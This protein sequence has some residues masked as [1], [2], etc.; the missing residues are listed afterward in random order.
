MRIEET[1]GLVAERPLG[2]PAARARRAGG[3]RGV[4]A[5]GLASHLV[6][7]AWGLLVAL[8]LAWMVMT[9]FK[10]DAEIFFSPWQLPGAWRW[11]NFARAW[12]E[13]QIGRYALN[14]LIVVAGSVSLTLLCA[15]MAAY[16][17]ARYEF[18]LNRPIYYAFLVGLAFPGFLALVPVFFVVRDLGLLGTYRGLILVYSAGSLPFAV[19]FLTGFF[20]SLPTELAEAAILDGASHHRVFFQIMLP[21]ARPGLAAAGIFLFL[22]HW[23]QF[24][25]PFVLNPDPDRYLLAQGLAALAVQRGYESDWSALFAGLTLTMLPTLLFYLLFQRRV[26]QGLTAGALKG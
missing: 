16:A 24:I 12:N 8:P 21:M 5:G 17:L 23:N 15:S 10:S 11:G 4:G 20:R 1:S 26:Q 9:A 13:A 19:F 18:R 2:L 22:D 6:L 3:P 14:S 25:L 7:G